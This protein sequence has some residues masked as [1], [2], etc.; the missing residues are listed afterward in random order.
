M[1]RSEWPPRVITGFAVS[2]QSSYRKIEMQVRKYRN[3]VTGEHVYAPNDA[4]DC[5]PI[6]RAV[7]IRTDA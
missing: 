2:K 3:K 7:R 6:G 5:L 4:P 1:D